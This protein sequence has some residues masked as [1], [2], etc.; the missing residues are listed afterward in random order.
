MKSTLKSG[1]IVVLVCMFTTVG[2]SFA[3]SRLG[4]L[5]GS[6]MV[7]V[8]Q[9]F[10]RLEGR[11]DSV[12]KMSVKAGQNVTVLV[13]GDESTDLDVWV[14]DTDGDLV[15]AGEEEGDQEEVHFKAK[16]TGI[17]TIR[18]SNLGQKIN[19]YQLSF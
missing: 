8:E 18:V 3:Q 12:H 4:I 1:S 19:T 14:Y 10:F 11:K 5:T 15:G 9:G 2:P 7:Q 6:Y 16:Q 17:Y 13:N